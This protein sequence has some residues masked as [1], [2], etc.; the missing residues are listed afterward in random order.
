M[1]QLHLWG[2][3]AI[4]AATV[5]AYASDRWRMEIVAL[6]SL[7]ALLALFELL[8]FARGERTLG[9]EGL[10]AGFANPALA[11]VIALMIVGQ[12]LFATDAMDK[13]SRAIARLGGKSARRA[14]LVILIA[15]GVL[16]AVLNN[17]PVVVIFIPI[18]AVLAAQRN[19]PAVRAFMPLSFLTILGGMTTLIGSSTNLLVAGVAHNAGIEIDFFD[20]TVMGSILAV[21]GALYVLFVMPAMLDRATPEPK[22]ETAKGTQFV[23]EIRLGAGHP[24][25]GVVSR[26]GFFPELKELAPRTIIRRDVEIN[27]PF[28]DTVLSEGDRLVVNTTR[29]AL[30]KALARGSAEVGQRAGAN[31]GDATPPKPAQTNYH[32]AEAVVAPGSRHAGRTVKNAGIESSHGVQVI[33]VQRKARM[34]RAALSEIRLEPGDTILV[35]GTYSAITALRYSHDLLLLEWSAEA[36]PRTRKAAIAFVI[37]AAVVAASALSLMPIV[38]AAIIGAVAMLLTGC[39][40]LPEALRAFDGRIYLMVGASIALATALE[41]TGGARMIAEGAVAAFAGQSPAVVLSVLFAVIALTTNVLS[42]N[43]AAV[44]FAPIAINAADA[45]G[46]PREAFL[47]AVIFAANASFATPIAYQTNLL[48]MGPGHYS[49]ADFVRCGAPLVAIIWLTFSLIAPWYYGL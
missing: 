43:A 2:T 13:P 47:G 22:L 7:A 27:P 11:T 15:A 34:G 29:S 42:N 26:A 31:D 49:F 3:Y 38:A 32:L 12:G 23:G 28:E 16:S 18:L 6:A 37:F 40:T 36:V 48:V 46:A 20:I 39:L 21:T 44:L 4:I 24:L 8:P 45:L 41:A 10:I 5:V 14:I 25:I 33:G 19:Y 35:G 1:D 9:A 17:T 30:A